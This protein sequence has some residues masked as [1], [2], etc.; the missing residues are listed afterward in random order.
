MSV[1]YPV[2]D[3]K[4]SRVEGVGIPPLY[5]ANFFQKKKKSRK[6]MVLRKRALSLPLCWFGNYMIT[7]GGSRISQRGRQ[8]DR[9]SAN[10]LWPKFIKN[11]MKMK[12]IG[13]RGGHASKILLCRS[14]LDNPFG[15]DAVFTALRIYKMSL[16]N[17]KHI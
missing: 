9:G 17:F 14:A 7:S 13:P 11:C 8:S 16:M 3:K 4:I 12:K 6:D 1:Y 15:Y 2:T 5:F 10:L